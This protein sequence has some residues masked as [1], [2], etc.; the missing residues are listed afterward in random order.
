MKNKRFPLKRILALILALVTICSLLASCKS[1]DEGDGSDSS[2]DGIGINGTVPLFVNG[3]YGARVIHDG[4]PDAKN[5]AEQLV[6]LVSDVTGVPLAYEDSY[7]NYAGP[8]ILIGATTYQESISATAKLTAGQATAAISGNKYVIAFTSKESADK[9]LTSFGAKLLNTLPTEIIINSTWNFSEGIT[10]NSSN[11]SNTSNN[12]NISTAPSTGN[13]TFDESTL[14]QSAS[15]PALGTEKNAGQG[16]KTYIK[17]GA[18]KSTFTS[19]CGSLENNGFKKYTTNKIDNNEFATYLTKTQIVHVMF[20]ANKSEVRTA[21]D[22][23]GTGTNGFDITGLSG[24]NKYTKKVNP[25]LTLCEIENADWPG[26]L[27]MIFKLSDG[28]FFVVDS[29][30]GGRDANGGSSSGWVYASLAKHADDPKNIKVAA[31]LITHVHSDHA[32]GLLDIARGWYRK[33]GSSTKHKVM[34]QEAKQYIKIERLIHNA[35]NK[36]PDSNRD[37]WINEIINAF[38]IKSVVKAHPGQVFYISDLTLTIYASQ[39]L[40]I[41]QSV[42]NTNEQSLVARATFNGKSILMLGDTFPKVNK[43]IATIYKDSLKSDILQAAHHGYN[44]TDAATVNKLC[45]PSIVLW[46]VSTGDMRRENILNVAVNV[47][48]KGKTSYAPHGGN[49]VFDHNWKKSK[50]SNATILNMIPKCTCGCGKKS[51]YSPKYD[52]NCPCSECK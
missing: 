27:C 31:W 43:V 25:S 15:L 10:T 18:S 32:G 3:A 47:P 14:K 46:P 16:S 33:N 9:I 38:S 41:D 2:S 19:I 8:A 12:S 20:L 30:I 36:L 29:G 44:N 26:G 11:N 45:N 23:R 17:T 5:I 4:T 49:I 40:I 21:V 13:T 42:G 6:K 51:S 48:L 1:N 24:D 7:A 52:S 39:D 28:R 22:K 50:I 34:P 35:P 37:G